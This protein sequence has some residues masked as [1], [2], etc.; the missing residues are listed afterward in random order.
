MFFLVPVFQSWTG[1][2]VGIFLLS[3]VSESVR[4][5]SNVSFTQFTPPELQTRAFGLQRMALNLGLSVGPA[6][7]GL[8][9]EINFV[10]LFIVDGIT[11]GLGA[12]F[13]LKYFGFRKFA[14]NGAAAEMQKQSEQNQSTGSPLADTKFLCC[15][16]LILMVSLVFFQ[17]HATYP[18]YLE[19]HYGLSKPQIGF[20][21]AV[22]TVIIVVFE[23]LLVNFV[24]RFSLL[25]T[26]GWGSFLA[27]IG[28]G[29]L[30]A[31]VAIWFVV[32]SMVI[33]TMGEML[34]FPLATGF[35]AERSTGR[36]QGMYMSWYAITYS[37]A[38]V[39]APLLGSIIYGVDPDL[40]WYFSNVIG[41]VVLTGFYWL[42]AS[43][44]REEQNDRSVDARA[45]GSE[46]RPDTLNQATEID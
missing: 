24:R 13:L 15:L 42:S 34:M 32:L 10:W 36:D 1:V 2:A 27:C 21:F 43:V 38:A 14:R 22:N 41:V 23:M 31:S 30:P 3:V 29:I 4:P 18:K 19:D 39:I 28:F 33:I 12:I 11:T 7:G 17:F 5:A 44:K 6:V 46:S 8:L 35:V 37:V 9:A 45:F 40:F 26:I 20:L 16:G 25:R